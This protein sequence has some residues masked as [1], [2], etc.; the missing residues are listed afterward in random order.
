MIIIHLLNFELGQEIDEPKNAAAAL[1]ITR[2][3]RFVEHMVKTL[4]TKCQR[5]RRAENTPA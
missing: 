3:S 5:L 2:M 4:L 1:L